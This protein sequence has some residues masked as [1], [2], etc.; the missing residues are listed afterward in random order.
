MDSQLPSRLCGV[1]LKKRLRDLLT[2]LN[3]E[4]A[5]ESVMLL[6]LRASMLLFVLSGCLISIGSAQLSECGGACFMKAILDIPSCTHPSSA[7]INYLDIRTQI[8]EDIQDMGAVW[9]EFFLH[10]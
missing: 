3:R 8:A 6:Y 4:T 7:Q 10:C 1:Y 2:L 9:T 5:N